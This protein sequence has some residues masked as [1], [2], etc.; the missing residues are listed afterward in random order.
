MIKLDLTIEYNDGTTATY[1]TGTPEWAK[2]ERKTGK[3][4]YD[5]TAE[6]IAAHGIGKYFQQND[7]LFLAH[8][9]Y[10]RANAG[11]P[12]KPYEIWELTVDGIT[13]EPHENPKV[14]ASEA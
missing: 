10:T 3:S 7:F 9:A 4:V 8:S 1:F 13:V 12:S 5:A 2:W 14:S 6:N 11:K